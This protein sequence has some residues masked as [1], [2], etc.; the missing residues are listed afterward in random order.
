MDVAGLT[1]ICGH[2]ITGMKDEVLCFIYFSRDGRE[3]DD[4]IWGNSG[5]R[6]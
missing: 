3:K 1:F 4:F 5:Y 6:P 2:K